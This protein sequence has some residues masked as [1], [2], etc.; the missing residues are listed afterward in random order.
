MVTFVE[1]MEVK[2]NPLIL[3][4]KKCLTGLNLVKLLGDND[5]IFYRLTWF[6]LKTQQI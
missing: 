4:K 2:L 6:S 3:L 1:I 5:S